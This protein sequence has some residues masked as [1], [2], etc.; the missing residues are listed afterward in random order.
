MP[1]FEVLDRLKSVVRMYVRYVRMLWFIPVLIEFMVNFLYSRSEILFKEMCRQ[2][3]I[4]CKEDPPRK[5]GDFKTQNLKSSGTFG[6]IT[7]AYVCE[8]FSS[9]DLRFQSW[10]S[11]FF[12]YLWAHVYVYVHVYVYECFACVCMRKIWFQGST[13]ARLRIRILRVSPCTCMHTYIHTRTSSSWRSILHRTHSPRITHKC[14][15]T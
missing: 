4:I 15:H 14:I 2:I 13:T 9:N 5:T 12:R 1:S 11:E 6:R 8:T 3:S 10:E 7:N